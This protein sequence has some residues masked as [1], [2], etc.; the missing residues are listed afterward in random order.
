MIISEIIF[1]IFLTIIW[2][3]K[4]FLY[5][6]KIK[7]ILAFL[8]ASIISDLFLDNLSK[9]LKKVSAKFNVQIYKYNMHT[10]L[11]PDNYSLNWSDMKNSSSRH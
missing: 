9:Y 7:P 6:T 3:I 4:L 11:Y 2:S 5:Q 10:Y 8:C 1:C